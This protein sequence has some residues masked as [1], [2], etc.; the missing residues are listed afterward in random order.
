MG[1][2]LKVIGI[3][4]GVITLTLILSFRVG[5]VHAAAARNAAAAKGAAVS[6]SPRVA[7]PLSDQA[8]SGARA[9]T[10]LLGVGVGGLTL[11]GFA[12]LASRSPR[13]APGPL[14]RRR[15]PPVARVAPVPKAVWVEG[16]S[17]DG[18]IGDFAGRAI[19]KARLLPAGGDEREASTH[20]WV[21]D[22]NTPALVWVRRDEIHRCRWL[23]PNGASPGERPGVAPPGWLRP[24][25]LRTVLPSGE[26]EVGASVVLHRASA[27][28]A[29]GGLSEEALE[30]LELLRIAERARG[31]AHPVVPALAEFAREVAVEVEDR[32]G[33]DLPV[34]EVG[35][36]GER[37]FE[38]VR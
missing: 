19:A 31:V 9:P 24:Q 35:A 6:P 3:A 2:D 30:L 26:L 12:V 36:E 4:V 20:Y 7:R 14:R 38:P 28:N 37:S 13:R 23:H 16:R 27:V 34:W 22:A 33:P 18:R 5:Y 29:L 15:R 11:I 10:W 25:R 21:H 1:D 8:K 17:A 32:Q